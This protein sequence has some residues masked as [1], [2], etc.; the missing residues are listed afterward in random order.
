VLW[1]L[2]SDTSSSTGVE[3]ASLATAIVRRGCDYATIGFLMASH[4][5]WYE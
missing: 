2:P 5:C 4:L 3:L 1:F